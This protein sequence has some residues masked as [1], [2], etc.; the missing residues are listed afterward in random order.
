MQLTLRAALALAEP[1]RKATVMA[2][3]SGLDNVVRSVNVME[4]PNILDWVHPG[5]LLVTTMYPLRD[6]RAAIR[7]LIPRL[8]EKGLAGLA[9]TVESYLEGLLPTMLAD[10]DRLGFPLIKLPPRVSF[11]DIIQPL[12]S[13]ILDL[14]ADELRQSEAILRRFLDLVL[15]GGD[16]ADIAQVLAEVVGHPVSIVDRFRRVLGSDGELSGAWESMFIERDGVGDAYLRPTYR[17]TMSDIEGH[18]AMHA[19]V[20]SGPDSLEHLVC[21]VEVSSSEL[22]TI[23]VWGLISPDLEPRA[24]MAIEHGATVIA[25]KM[26]EKL[27][28]R[29]VEQQFRNEILEGLLSDQGNARES[30]IQLSEHLG[31]R[32]RPPYVVLL[33]GPDVPSE[34]LLAQKE[35]SE[36]NNVESS[37]HLAQRYIHALHEGSVSWRKGPYLVAFFPRER[38]A[39]PEDKGQLVED[40]ARVCT[41]IESENAPHT[42]SIGVSRRAETLDLFRQAYEE[43]KHSFEI[44]RALGGRGAGKVAHYDDLGIFRLVPTAEASPTVR[45]FCLDLLGPLLARDDAHSS[46]LLDTLRVFLE[47]NQNGA[48]AAKTLGI[49][50][51]TLRYRLARIRETLGQDFADPKR[52]LALEVALHL[53]PFL[54]RSH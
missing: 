14:Q 23:I 22:G 36:R 52:R 47:R 48:E 24:L 45:D 53:Y 4:V 12:T 30:A 7:T 27:S 42:V 37:L 20:D 46:R 44:G 28:I 38:R 34:T 3:A 9:V 1:L 33:V 17:P 19:R 39:T 10:A 8:A 32:L 49:H 35:R 29:Q 11:V 16:Y 54:S 31:S 2:G 18:S 43:A 26:M 6:D 51:N 50:Y 15:V 13:R 5:E 40:L 25:L 41:R 21:P